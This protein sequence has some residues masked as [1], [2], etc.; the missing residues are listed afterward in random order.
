V[1]SRGTDR[2]KAMVAALSAIC[3]IRRRHQQGMLFRSTCSHLAWVTSLRRAPV[4]SRSKIALAATWFSSVSRDA[5]GLLGGQ[6]QLPVDLGSRGKA[7]CG[8]YG[9][10]RHIPLSGEVVDVTQDHQDTIRGRGDVPLA[11]S[12]ICRWNNK[13]AE[14]YEYARGA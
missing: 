13:F 3:R 1:G 11:A 4:S 6:K 14:G 8:I 9:G 10:T 7:C 2:S 12:R 5:L